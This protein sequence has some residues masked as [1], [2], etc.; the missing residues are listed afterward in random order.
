MPSPAAPAPVARRHLWLL[1]LAALLPFLCLSLA[2]AAAWLAQHQAGMERVAEQRVVHLAEAVDRELAAQ[3]EALAMLA[4]AL[5]AAE[6]SGG[7]DVSGMMARA[8]EANP[9]WR[10]LLLSDAAGNRVAEASAD[11]DPGPPRV[12]DMASHDAVLATGKPQVGGVVQGP[13][14]GTAFAMRVP[15]GLATPPDRVLS[16]VIGT[17]AM[18]RLLREAG[19]PPDWV[20]VVVD[21]SDNIVARSRGPE[22]LL[23]TRASDSVLKA[24]RSGQ[25]GFYDSVGLD[26]IPLRSVYRMLPSF[27]WSIHFGIP[28]EAFA[29][30]MRRAMLLLAGGGLVCLCLA[31]GFS[32]LFLREMRERRTAELAREEAGRLEAMGQMTR[33]V[34]HDFNNLL[35]AVTACL[36]LVERRAG[37]A[38]L[39][40]VLRA[41]HQAVERG[42]RLTGQLLAFARRQSL[43]P[44]PVSL[45]DLLLGM[46]ELA[47]KTL[48]QDIRL[49]VELEPGLWPASADPV[50]LEATLLNLLAN[51]RDA[52]PGPG[53][54]TIRARNRE[55]QGLVALTVSDT[56][57]GMAPQTA[58]RAIEPF[59]T[60]KLGRGGTGLGLSQAY[61][62]ASQSGG[63][64]HID[65]REGEG[66]SVTL[67]LPRA[68]EQPAPAAGPGAPVPAAAGGRVLLV[69]DDPVVG[70]L[71]A[72]GLREL[73]FTV[74]R[75]ASADEALA[76]LD[77]GARA[78]VVLSDIVMPGSTSGVGLLRE[79][80][81]RWPGLPVVLMTGYSEELD[82]LDGAPLLRK[83]ATLADLSA[84]LAT[85]R[86]PAEAGAAV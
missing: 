77:A 33:G 19:L 22:T 70:P 1:A 16:A 41:G 27:G 66:T 79:V 39:S 26:G 23:G 11:G 54:V 73:G 34:A 5:A 20:G 46:S 53:T 40:E 80:R 18:G 15:M 32:W 57:T 29:A 24:R 55:G 52:L 81:R 86:H 42:A 44:R 68:L 4:A 82:G 51:A 76:V 6:T 45:R 43:E 67:L 28:R 17:A 12:V 62:F 59:F 13:R 83:P 64:L 63:S 56:G 31:G 85:A 60:T 35:Q 74:E 50:Q 7:V 69:E 75:A 25:E 48:R 84:A 49:E 30:P 78:D 58:A 38:G 71:L 10:R 65:S 61:G 8:R 9:L 47:A 36:V 14:G 72:A 2:L 21:G 3:G 37:K